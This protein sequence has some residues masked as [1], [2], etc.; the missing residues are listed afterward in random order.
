MKIFFENIN[1]RIILDKSCVQRVQSVL[2]AILHTLLKINLFKRPYSNELRRR[3]E[4]LSTRIYIVLLSVSISILILFTSIS[5]YTMT[6]KVL[7]PTI[8]TYRQLEAQYKSTLSCPCNNIT[9]SYKTFIA[10]Q[11]VSYY[12]HIL[13]DFKILRKS[14]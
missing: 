10:I 6:I 13:G 2:K 14:F 5:E 3:S 4:I 1:L 11:P 9:A 8:T 7:S 12:V